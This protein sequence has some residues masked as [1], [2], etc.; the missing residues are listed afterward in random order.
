M[1]DFVVTDTTPG[2]QGAAGEGGQSAQST[3]SRYA[4]RIICERSPPY[5]TR[6]Y[7]A[8][9]DSSKNIFLGVSGGR[10][11]QAL[12][13]SLPAPQP[14]CLYGQTLALPASIQLIST[15]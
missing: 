5:T 10:S 1:I 15:N 9:F 12:P 11:Q 4:C 8:G 6:I 7:A 14:S 3:I 2:S 13:G